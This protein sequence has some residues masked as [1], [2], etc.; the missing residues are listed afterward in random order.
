MCI[1]RGGA[2]WFEAESRWP[3]CHVW[4]VRSLNVSGLSGVF[5]FQDLNYFFFSISN[6]TIRSRTRGEEE[7]EE[8][9]E[10]YKPVP[11]H[12]D[13]WIHPVWV[14]M[15]SANSPAG[16]RLAWQP[17]ADSKIKPSAPCGLV[18]NHQNFYCKLLRG[19][20]AMKAV[21]T[22]THT[23]MRVTCGGGVCRPHLAVLS[24]GR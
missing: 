10:D 1:C 20:R 9:E 6:V 2:S 17:R 24:A 18:C 23:H 22:H 14:D 11:W 15:I 5:H 16:W 13:I 3:S 12:L 21:H 19:I 8:E 7:E 4:R